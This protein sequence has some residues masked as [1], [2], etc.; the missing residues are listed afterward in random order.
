MKLNKII[1]LMVLF[2][3]SFSSSKV[4]AQGLTD[5][6]YIDRVRY[7]TAGPIICGGRTQSDY[8]WWERHDVPPR[9]QKNTYIGKYNVPAP[10]F[11]KN[12]VFLTAGQRFGDNF[13]H[14]LLTGQF[15]FDEVGRRDQGAW[16]K[17]TR[18]SIAYQMFRRNIYSL[19]DTF[20]ALAF[21]ARFN[22]NFSTSNKRDIVDAY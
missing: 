1:L 4:T 14:E 11:V 5:E 12:I 18:N 17:I 7:C 21:D 16:G 2:F 10:E 22:N 20:A 3:T 8:H 19:D 15:G 13:L 9:M 6:V